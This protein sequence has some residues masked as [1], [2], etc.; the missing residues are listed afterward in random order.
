[1]ST[2][3]DVTCLLVYPTIHWCPDVHSGGLRHYC[4]LRKFKTNALLCGDHHQPQPY[5]VKKIFVCFSIHQEPISLNNKVKIK[6]KSSGLLNASSCIF[7]IC[8]R[9]LCFFWVNITTAITKYVTVGNMWVL[10]E[11]GMSDIIG[12]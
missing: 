5:H 11:V 1:M 6:C 7:K 9:C 3:V 2:C 8:S 12:R 4:I 10:C